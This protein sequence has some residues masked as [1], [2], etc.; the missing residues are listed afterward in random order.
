MVTIILGIVIGIVIMYLGDRYYGPD[1]M[2]LISGGLIGSIIGIVVSISLPMS[3]EINT[4]EYNIVTLQDNSHVSGGLF[5]GTGS[6]NGS[7]KYVFYYELPNGGFKMNQISYEN[8][9]II[10]SNDKK[11][12]I[13]KEEPTNSFLNWFAIDLEFNTSYEIYVPKGTISNDF[14]LDAQ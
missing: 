7:M 14:K 6:I 11:V 13:Y 2:G 3:K 10:Y 9:T 12:I 5:L 1:I 8:T 4:Y